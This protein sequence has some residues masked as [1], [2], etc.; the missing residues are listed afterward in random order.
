MTGC[1]HTTCPILRPERGTVESSN[2]RRLDHDAQ[3]SP[4]RAS[5]PACRELATRIEGHRRKTPGRGLGDDV[6]VADG[7]QG[8]DAPPQRVADRG[9]PGIGGVL[10]SRIA[11][12]KRLRK[13]ASRAERGWPGRCSISAV[14]FT[15]SIV[16]ERPG[17]RCPAHGTISVPAGCCRRGRRGAARRSKASRVAAP[18]DRGADAPLW[19][20][21]R[22][23]RLRGRHDDLRPPVRVDPRLGARPFR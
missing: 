1:T 14:T 5:S 20:S 13:A 3:D 15:V 22:R 9:E 10:G 19:I 12:S 11:A 7:G 17:P 8:D 21:E 18:E 6:P 2:G 16:P 23:A 4:N